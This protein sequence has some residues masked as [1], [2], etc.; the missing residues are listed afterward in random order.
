MY[1]FRSG[2]CNDQ[3]KALYTQRATPK[4]QTRVTEIMIVGFCRVLFLNINF[5]SKSVFHNIFGLRGRHMSHIAG[6]PFGVYFL[7]GTV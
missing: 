7:W 2:R 6:R 1:E 5:L 4:Q 3:G